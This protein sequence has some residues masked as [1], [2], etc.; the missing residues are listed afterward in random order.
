MS[1]VVNVAAGIIL[2]GNLILAARRKV[3]LHLGGF[4]EFPGGKVELGE[5]PEN[6]LVRELREEFSIET[7]IVNYVG[8]NLHSYDDK[9]I[10]LIAYQVKHICG[11]F[12]LTDHDDIKWLKI[13]ELNDL[14][15]APADIPLIEQFKSNLSIQQ[16]YQTNAN[17]YAKET[18]SID[19]SA[20]YQRFMEHIPEKSHLLDLGCGSGRD[21][22]FFLKHHFEV[23]A[24]DGCAALAKL[25]E[26]LIRHPVLVQRFQDI[27]FDDV[28]DGVWACASLLHC[29]KYE[30]ID[31]LQR[32]KQ[33]LKISGIFYAS[34]KSGD[35][36]T[37]DNSGRFFNNYT[38]NQLSDLV[39]SI[40]GFEI[41]DCWEEQRPLR[42]STQKWVNILCR[43]TDRAE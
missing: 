35:K 2:K 17:D 39:D 5:S 43:K 1:E 26:D 4:W 25:A 20:L 24:L 41:I 28:F 18:L 32:V 40:G 8:E 13:D 38:V 21:S 3:G 30:M 36:E 42:S 9:T 33:A 23:T 29:P 7:A 19:L 22:D 12:L 37:C 16:F 10:R 11:E 6:C 27:E 31:V 15:W 34:F 14:K